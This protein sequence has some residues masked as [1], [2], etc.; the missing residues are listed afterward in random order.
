M[1]LSI[2]VFILPCLNM[3]WS[4]TALS[5]TQTVRGVETSIIAQQKL[6]NTDKNKKQNYLILV[7]IYKN[8]KFNNC[9]QLK[10]N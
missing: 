6:E 2:F 9:N 5:R 8:L 10:P 3:L 1:I 7:D 4:C